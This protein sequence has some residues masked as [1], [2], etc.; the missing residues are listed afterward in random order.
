[1]DGKS[2]KI[3]ISVSFDRGPGEWG[4]RIFRDGSG[5]LHENETSPLWE[6]VWL[7]G[8]KGGSRWTIMLG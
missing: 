6:G 4:C 2:Q 8:A 5:V 3:G 1:M 7:N